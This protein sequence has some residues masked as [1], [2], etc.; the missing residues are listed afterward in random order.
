MEKL[1]QNTFDQLLNLLCGENKWVAYCINLERCT[2]RKKIFQDWAKFCGLTFNWWKATDKLTLT[3]EDYKY[4]DVYVNG[5]I[6]SNGATACRLSHHYL[7]KYLLS[8]DEYKDK[9][10]FFIL[11]DDAGFT[12]PEEDLK[13]LNDY[14]KNIIDNKYKWDHLWFGYMAGNIMKRFIPI[15]NYTGILAQTHLTHAMLFK[16]N[17]LQLHLQILEDEKFKSLA[18]DWT[19]DLIRINK[20]G[21]TLG[22]VKNIIQQIDENSFIWN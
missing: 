9:E 11:E 17:Q 6:K 22:P 4:C 18:V 12:N 5:T 19:A 15:S 14:I 20:L 8:K 3:D 10:Y 2:E 1:N 21:V 16:R 7:I 13:N